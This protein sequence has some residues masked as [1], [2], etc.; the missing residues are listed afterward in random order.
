MSQDQADGLPTTTLV[1]VRGVWVHTEDGEGIDLAPGVRPGGM[2]VAWDRLGRLRLEFLGRQFRRLAESMG[3]VNEALMRIPPVLGAALSAAGRYPPPV[4]GRREDRYTWCPVDT[5]LTREHATHLV[6]T[7]AP[8]AGWRWCVCQW[9]A[10]NLVAQL[11]Q[12]DIP[13]GAYRYRQR[14]EQRRVLKAC[15]T[16]P[17]P[18]WIGSRTPGPG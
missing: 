2:V 10:V 15:V 5:H 13:A 3:R 1:G 4:V 12:Q 17:C 7:R 6:K 11:R 14:P 9:C 8:A 16:I 18:P